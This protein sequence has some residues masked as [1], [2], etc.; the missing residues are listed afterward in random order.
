M[1][2]VAHFVLRDDIMILMFSTNIWEMIAMLHNL[3]N[4]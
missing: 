2:F 4:I 3:I 1:V